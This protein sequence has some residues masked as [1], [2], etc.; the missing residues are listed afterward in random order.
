M[1]WFRHAARVFRK[2]VLI[3][4]KTGEITATTCF[5]SAL[6]TIAAS[7]AL[8]SGPDIGARV[9]PALIW[10][11]TAFSSVLAVAKSWQRERD[12]SAFDG[13]LVLP[14]SRSAILAGKVAS[15]IVFLAISQLVTIL[16][17]A[18]LFSI[19]LSAVGFGV[20]LITAAALPGICVTGTLF[21]AMTV[22]TGARELVLSCV[23]LPLLLP[24]LLAAVSATRELFAGAPVASLGDYFL[25]MAAF[26]VAFAAGG[27]A[28]FGTMI[29]G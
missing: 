16:L 4:R 27:L 25:I 24:V 28:L 12:D 5:F 17:V 1:T 20:L 3:E 9:A 7:F 21:G 8:Q 11:V 29:E 22:R 18:F 6:M 15:L 2:D 26:D 19:D 13:L 10:I 14:I 23:V